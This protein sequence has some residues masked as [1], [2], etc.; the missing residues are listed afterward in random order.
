MAADFITQDLPPIT[1][2]PDEELL[3]YAQMKL[4]MKERL[5]LEWQQELL[6]RFAQ[7]LDREASYL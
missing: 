1:S 2:L 6:K 3:K 7:T 5:P 4:D